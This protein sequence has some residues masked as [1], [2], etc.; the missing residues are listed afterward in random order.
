M[1]FRGT[2]LST[3]LAL[4]GPNT[5]LE[6]SRNAASERMST[7]ERGLLISVRPWEIKHRGYQ[8]ITQ[9]ALLSSK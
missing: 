9:T 7:P 4:F 8:F 6:T 2:F 1:N 3:T 5:T